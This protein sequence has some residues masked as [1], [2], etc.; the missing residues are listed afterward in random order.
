MSA[1]APIALS[2]EANQAPADGQSTPRGPTMTPFLPS[3]KYEPSRH[4][5]KATKPGVTASLIGAARALTNLFLLDISRP[6]NPQNTSPPVR[7]L[8]LGQRNLLSHVDI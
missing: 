4:G 6:Q 8:Q 7:A 1:K 3:C 2:S 5:T